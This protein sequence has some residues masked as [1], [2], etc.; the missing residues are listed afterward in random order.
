MEDENIKINVG[1]RKISGIFCHHNIGKSPIIIMCHGYGSSKNSEKYIKLAKLFSE[2]GIAS[3]RFDFFGHGQS[4]GKFEDFTIEKGLEDVENVYRYLVG[5][6][7]VD[8]IKIGIFGSSMGGSVSILTTS[9]FNRFNIKSM[10]LSAPAID[11]SSIGRDALEIKT[12][13][14]DAKKY[15][16]YKKAGWIKCSTLIVHGREDDV[17][18]LKQSEKFLEL[19]SLP[20]EKKKLEIF[21]GVDHDFTGPDLDRLV[22]LSA[23]WLVKW[24]K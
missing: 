8:N 7:F 10:V 15:N 23:D 1:T 6:E 20:P 9:E 5:S 14:E 11:Y 18:P 17:V 4:D 16:L 3:L 12:F 24:L 21:E 13:H 2:Q 22:E 19:L